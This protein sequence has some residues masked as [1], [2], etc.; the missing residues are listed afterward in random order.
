MANMVMSD[1]KNSRSRM[2]GNCGMKHLN[3]QHNNVLL[4]LTDRMYYIK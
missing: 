2:G 3:W 1:E 4:T